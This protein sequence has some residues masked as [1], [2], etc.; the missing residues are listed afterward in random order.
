[1]KI[2]YE[3]EIKDCT[4]CPFYDEQDIYS[5]G[6][7][8]NTLKVTVFTYCYKTPVPRNYIGLP[9]KSIKCPIEVKI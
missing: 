8:I 2:K 1:M 7:E 5:N 4:E 6:G 9:S 3:S